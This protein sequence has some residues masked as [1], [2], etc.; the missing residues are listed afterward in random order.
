MD[1]THNVRTFLCP[2]EWFSE[3]QLL[4]PEISNDKEVGCLFCDYR[5]NQIIW[6]YAFEMFEDEIHNTN[7]TR[8][9][10]FHTYTEAK[11][12]L[13]LDEERKA[14]NMNKIS[15]TKKSKDDISGASN[16]GNNKAKDSKQKKND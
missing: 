7:K 14:R 6:N 4:Y 11:S 8:Y 1:T 5:K 12:A 3:V 16:S 13:I 15:E 9:S 2:I 10:N